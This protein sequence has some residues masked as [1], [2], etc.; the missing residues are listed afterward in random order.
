MRCSNTAG[1]KARL[2]WKPSEHAVIRMIALMVLALFAQYDKP[3]A[4]AAANVRS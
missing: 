1:P 3:R 2:N 4:R